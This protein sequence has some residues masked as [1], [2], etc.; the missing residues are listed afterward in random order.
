MPTPSK[1]MALMPEEHR[2]RVQRVALDFL[3]IPEDTVKA[4]VDILTFK[5]CRSWQRASSQA[6]TRSDAYDAI[7]G[8]RPQTVGLLE[9]RKDITTTT[10]HG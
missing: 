4:M 3:S 7:T 10:D 8:K 9:E 1:M 6:W 2:S 5:R